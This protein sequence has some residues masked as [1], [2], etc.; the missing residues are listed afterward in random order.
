MAAAP[1]E[2]GVAAV[3]PAE[4][5]PVDGQKNAQGEIYDSSLDI[6]EAQTPAEDE[7]HT[8]PQEARDEARYQAEASGTVK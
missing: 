2:A 1:G 8:A 4:E 3:L 6:P 7:W 5:T